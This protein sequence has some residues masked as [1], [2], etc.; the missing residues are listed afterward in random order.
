MQGAE[1]R[2]LP[3]RR[4]RWHREPLR[5]VRKIERLFQIE[6]RV[7]AE[8]GGR[9]G[10]RVAITQDGELAFAQGRGS[11]TGPVGNAHSELRRV[12]VEDGQDQ[13]RPWFR[14]RVDV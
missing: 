6:L 1:L 2:C 8:T 10:S 7:V 12:V 5:R 11:L 3:V 9:V 4:G 14:A 13:S